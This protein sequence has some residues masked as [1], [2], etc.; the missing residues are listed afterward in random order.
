LAVPKSCAISLQQLGGIVNCFPALWTICLS[1]FLSVSLSVDCRLSYVKGAL[2]LQFVCNA[3]LRNERQSQTVIFDGS[4]TFDYVYAMLSGLRQKERAAG[5][6]HQVIRHPN[7]QLQRPKPQ[8][9]TCDKSMS[10]MK[11]FGIGRI[12]I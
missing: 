5:Q 7:L 6:S 11:L 10:V 2:P 12:L 1:V 4:C 9:E 8:L 3:W